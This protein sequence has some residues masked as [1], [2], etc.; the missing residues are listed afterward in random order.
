MA[1]VTIDVQTLEAAI[2]RTLEMVRPGPHEH[3]SD[4]VQNQQTLRN[5]QRAITAVRSHPVL[6]RSVV[7]TL[8]ELALLEP[9]LET[10][11]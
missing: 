11:G 3:R 4:W 9:Y 2:K 7:L 6:G 1:D 8:D 10:A 5:L